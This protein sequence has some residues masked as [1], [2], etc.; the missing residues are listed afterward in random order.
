MLDWIFSIPS[1]V[2]GFVMVGTFVGLGLA[3]LSLTRRWVLPWLGDLSL[4]GEFT[5]T[6]HHGILIIYGLAVALI[7]VA[8]WENYTDATKLA[9]GEATALAALYR[10]AGGYPEPVR[11]QLRARIRD[12]TAEIIH[13]AWPLQR[14]GRVPTEGVELVDGIQDEMFAFIPTGEAQGILHAEALRAFN[15][16]VEARRLRLDAV[17]SALPPAMWAVV[18]FGGLI[19]MFASFLFEVRNLRLQRLVI[20]LLASVLGLLVFMIVRYDYP[21]RG[22]H[23]ISS[24]S[25]ELVFDHLMKP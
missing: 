16:M 11:S 8:V 4:A 15:I 3:G 25:Y 10:D 7:A 22:T 19:A 21:F 24:E 18:L 17:G 12:Y 20:A 5:A 6:V 23:G 2:L 14:S 9:S 1:F 13:L